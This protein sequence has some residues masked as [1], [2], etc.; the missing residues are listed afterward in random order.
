MP[1]API[2]AMTTP[3][4]L[5]GVLVAAGIGTITAAILAVLFLQNFKVLMEQEKAANPLRHLAVSLEVAGLPRGKF[6]LLQSL[7]GA[8]IGAMWFCVAATIALL[9]R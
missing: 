7:S 9:F 8:L 4:F 2:L 3:S 5:A 1:A 6:I